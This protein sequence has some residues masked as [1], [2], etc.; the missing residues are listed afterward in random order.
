[1]TSDEIKTM[2]LANAKLKHM[3]QIDPG[4]AALEETF[5]QL[6]RRYVKE[7][8]NGQDIGIEEPEQPEQ[9]PIPM[10]VSILASS[11]Q[12]ATQLEAM[13]KPDGMTD[14]DVAEALALRKEALSRIVENLQTKEQKS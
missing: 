8:L 14:A 10:A 12:R 11:C 13:H 3:S 9:M 1:M 7:H 6:S 5:D 4:R 2:F